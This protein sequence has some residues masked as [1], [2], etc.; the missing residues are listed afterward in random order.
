[1]FVNSSFKESVVSKGASIRRAT[2]MPCCWCLF[3]KA[4]LDDYATAVFGATVQNLGTSCRSGSNC[5]N[6]LTMQV[7]QYCH[8]EHKCQTAH[9]PFIRNCW[10]RFDEDLVRRQ[11][12]L[13]ASTSIRAMP[14]GYAF[15]MPP[16]TPSSANA[17]SARFRINPPLL[18]NSLGFF[19]LK[20]K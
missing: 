10:Q 11:G 2:R 19:A 16:A 7:V 8:A 5:L 14:N 18:V 1:M 6:L 15:P 3:C 4:G 9:R 12:S 20:G 13:L 17:P